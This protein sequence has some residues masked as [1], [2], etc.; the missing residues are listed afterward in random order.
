MEHFPER[1]ESVGVFEEDEGVFPS[2]E[3]A[4]HCQVGSARVE[5]TLFA[6]HVIRHPF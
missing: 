5:R 2:D 4:G 1:L 3:V 6:E